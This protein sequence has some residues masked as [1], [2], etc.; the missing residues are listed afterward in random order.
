VKGAAFLLVVAACAAAPRADDAPAA[1]ERGRGGEEEV[2]RYLEEYGYEAGD[3]TPVPDRW[4]IDLP[5]WERSGEP[6]SDYDA[7]YSRGGLLNPF[8]QNVLKGD[9]PIL[10]QNTFLVLTAT[11][12]TT[13]EARD[14]PTPSAVSTARPGSAD[15]FGSGEQRFVT[16]NLA[17]SFEL[18]RGNTAFK[19][20]DYLFRVTPVLNA[21]H[22]DVEENNAVSIDV[23]EGT[24]RTDGHV[25]LQE[26][27]L[28]KHILDLSSN[29]DFLS[30]TVGIQPF[31]GDFRGLVFLDSNLGARATFNLHSNRTQGSVAGFYM[32]EKE[33]NSDLNTFDERDQVV[34]AATL[35]RQ[36]FLWPGYTVQGAFFYNGDSGEAHLDDNGVPVRPPIL[37][38]ASEHELDVFYMGFSGDG[39]IGRLNLT[40]E[41]FFAF[42]EDSN[43]PLAQQPLDLEAHMFF[44]ELSVDVDWWRPR[45][46]FLWASG[47]DD[48]LDGQGRGF[49]SILDNPNVAGGQNSYWIRQGLRL[50]GVGLVQRLSA[51]PSLRSAKAEGQANFVNPGLL[52]WNLGAD[53]EVTQELRASLN[54]SYLRFDET[55]ALEPFVNQAV[56]SELGWEATLS[57]VYRP[58]LTNNIQIAAGLSAFFPGE[59]FSDLYE[60][61]E[62]LY[63]AFLQII[64]QY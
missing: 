59:G 42:G 32:L 4:R 38:N 61:R 21:N 44:L 60:S 12:D 10:G 11:S 36:D 48:P 46:S 18:F 28:E 40:H 9:Y 52:L 41:Y 57:G 25:G 30:A 22:L 54:A 7:P 17:L 35:L 13:F 37:G 6:S 8:R 15:F 2:E 5:P 23:R 19:P 14:L 50:L 34:A 47:D 62:T 39:H 51:Y 33:T 49:D 43:N 31:V 45:A 56:A 20:P 63:S 27:F 26:A 58:K 64:L 1:E 16:T 55:G 53:V 3:F 29:Y 24:S